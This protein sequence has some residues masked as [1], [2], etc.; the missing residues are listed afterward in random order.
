MVEDQELTAPRHVRDDALADE[1]VDEGAVLPVHA[2]VGRER[3]P[4]AV[5]DV[6]VDLVIPGG[7]RRARR[8]RLEEVV[9]V[10]HAGNAPA[11]LR[12]SAELA[13]DLH[14]E[15]GLLAQLA[16]GSLGGGLSRLQ[17]PAGH[18]RGERRLVGQVEDEQLVGAR[19]RLLARDVDDD[20]RPSVQRACFALY[21][22]FFAWYSSSASGESTSPSVGCPGSSSSRGRDAEALPQHR[23]ERLHLHLA[24]A[25]QLRD[26][27][28]QVGPV[29][30]LAPDA[31]GVAAV[32]LDH[33]G[34]E[35]L[36]APRHVAGEAV[37]RRLLAEDL[38]Q[39]RRDRSPRSGR[40]RAS[41]AA[42]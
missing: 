29:G 17:P 37:D 30:G 1:G 14:L 2:C 33:H 23:A 8:R 34:G 35:I 9:L 13:Y 12:L 41:P 20:S 31:L 32:L 19:Q 22:R 6:A 27:L 11:R 36:H 42:A 26:P 18:D 39:P 15:P 16:N 38:L 25:G 28:A 21:A 4:T 7:G 5:E 24:E 40:D 10:P 3:H